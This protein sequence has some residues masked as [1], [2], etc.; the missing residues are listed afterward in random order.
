MDN[1]DRPDEA[2]ALRLAECI[3]ALVRLIDTADRLLREYR[4]MCMDFDTPFDDEFVR[5]HSDL[6][7]M[8]TSLVIAGRRLSA[9]FNPNHPE[10]GK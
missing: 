7:L 4:L 8:R 6:V 9:R 2:M 3:I 10:P 1:A 5:S